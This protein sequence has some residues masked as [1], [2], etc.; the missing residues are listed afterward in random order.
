M[1]AIADVNDLQ[2]MN[3]DLTATYW[4]SND[5]D[6]LATVGWNGGAGFVPIGT[7]VN[8]FTGTLNGKNHTISNLYI[9]RPLEHYM[10]LFGYTSGSTIRN[11]T[12]ENFDITG[13][14]GIGALIG[15]ADVVGSIISDV[16]IINAT[17]E[18]DDY[19]G[20]LIGLSDDGCEINRC[21]STG[22]IIANTLI[23]AYAGGLVGG[24]YYSDVAECYSTVNVTAINGNAVGG[25]FGYIDPDTTVRDC[26]SRGDVIGDQEVGGLIGYTAGACTV[27]DSYSTGSVTGN[28]DIGG[29]IG[30]NMGGAA[31]ITNCFWDTETSGT[32]VSD[33]GTGK[34]TSQMKT[35]STFTDADWDFIVIW[36]I[37]GI[38]NDGYPFFWAMPPDPPPDAPRA[39]VAVQDKITLECVRNIEMAAGGRFYINEEGEAVYKSRYAR[40]L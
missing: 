17:L 39:T 27:D 16:R 3:N 26:F 8:P 29:L 20:G 13:D 14:W 31:I 36:F 21:S 2:D 28:L 5:I 30:D 19:I 32:A 4:L 6:A 9:N 37:N 12:L 18:G 24:C 38:T 25:L 23:A 34:T 22:G 40:N 35:K 11:L 15:R 7:A 1:P 10:G 33:G